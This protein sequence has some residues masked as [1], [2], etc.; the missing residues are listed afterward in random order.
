MWCDLKWIRRYLKNHKKTL[1]VTT[2]Q[3]CL[4]VKKYNSLEQ[5]SPVAELHLFD[6]YTTFWN[7]TNQNTV[8]WYVK[9]K[10]QKCSFISATKLRGQ[11][12]DY[13]IWNFI[14]HN[15]ICVKRKKNIKNFEY[16][17]E[18]WQNWTKLHT[19]NPCT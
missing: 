8:Q 11:K 12:F 13:T 16:Y 10:A 5:G 18:L 3:S 6:V 17:F 14:K 15:Q 19:L 2:V 9:L 4:C 7:W 1:K